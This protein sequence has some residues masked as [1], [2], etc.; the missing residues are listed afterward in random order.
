MT[1]LIVRNVG[2]K[3]VL[4]GPLYDNMVPLIISHQD[5]KMAIDF[6]FFN[7]RFI[8]FYFILLKWIQFVKFWLTIN[9]DFY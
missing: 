2:L 9:I 1:D 5:N 3:I 8:L 6:D 4:W 7:Y